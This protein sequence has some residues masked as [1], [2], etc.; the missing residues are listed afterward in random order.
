MAMANVYKVPLVLTAQPKG[1]YTVSSPALPELI[2]EGDSL[3]DALEHVQD[4]LEAVLEL[5]E[6]LG[7]PLP[8]ALRQDPQAETIVFEY[9]LAVA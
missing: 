6:D 5:Y 4:A 2:T 7:K 3:Q 9:P 8:A 1:G